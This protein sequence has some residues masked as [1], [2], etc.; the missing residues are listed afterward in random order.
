MSYGWVSLIDAL[1]LGAAIVSVF[2]VRSLMR[3]MASAN[4][5]A[6]PE[7]RAAREIVARQGE[8]SLS[9]FVL[10]PDKALQ[11]AAGGV[12]S[13]RVIRGTAIV[14]SDPVAPESQRPR[15][16]PSPLATGSERHRYL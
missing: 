15:W 9:P 8:D 2:A 3:P 16:L 6:E 7:H 14:S 4:R 10:R 11:F 1:I 5:H 13:D 12:L